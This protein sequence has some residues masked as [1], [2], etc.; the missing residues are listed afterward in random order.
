MISV[1]LDVLADGAARKYGSNLF[2][3]DFQLLRRVR[4]GF[5]DPALFIVFFKARVFRFDLVRNKL[6]QVFSYPQLVKDYRLFGGYRRRV[7]RNL[8]TSLAKK[9][10]NINVFWK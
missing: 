9:F 8:F 7:R 1:V 4:K 6:H 3:M 5:R 10:G 2:I